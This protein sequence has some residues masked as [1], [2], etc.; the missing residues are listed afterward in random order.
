LGKV[1]FEEFSRRYAPGKNIVQILMQGGFS[2]RFMDKGASSFAAELKML[3][4][5]CQDETPGKAIEMTRKLIQYDEWLTKNEMDALPRLEILNELQSSAMEY[6]SIKEYLEF[7]DLIVAAQQNK[8]DYDA[9]R[10]MTVHRSKGLEASV[11]FVAGVCEGVLP[12]G[13]ADDVQE[14]RRI[15]YVAVTRAIDRLYVSYFLERFKKELAPSRFL[16]EMLLEQRVGRPVMGE[17]EVAA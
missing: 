6:P 3:R 9:V 11:V 15:C 2:K 8:E 13:R 4:S 12:H 16:G 7:V 14:E 5:S 17:L 1:F 10:I